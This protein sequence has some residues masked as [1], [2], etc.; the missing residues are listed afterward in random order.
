MDDD[1]NQLAQAAH[2]AT[3]RV[4]AS[5]VR[6]NQLVIQAP[7]RPPRR[8]SAF[9][10]AFF[11]TFGVIAALVC[12]VLL[13][14]LADK[15]LERRP[16]STPKSESRAYELLREAKVLRQTVADTDQKLARLREQMKELESQ[17]L[18]VKSHLEPVIASEAAAAKAQFEAT[19]TY[20]RAESD[21]A[22]L[23]AARQ[24]DTPLERVEAA[25]AWNR[26]RMELQ[27]LRANAIL[28]APKRK[29][30]LDLEAKLTDLG[31]K[32]R[33]LQAQIAEIEKD[34][35][36]QKELLTAAENELIRPLESLSVGAWGIL[37]R[38]LTVVQVVDGENFIARDEEETL[39]CT[40]ISTNGM[41]DGSSWYLKKPLL[42]AGTTSYSDIRGAKR[43][44]YQIEPLGDLPDAPTTQPLQ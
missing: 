3:Q 33:S 26:A 14:G 18:D 40:G 19:D 16:A 9:F 8:R 24:K 42:V 2:S 28:A 7:G 13:I 36:H 25:G 34:S 15:V 22:A 35:I 20:R 29:V 5:R 6:P 17:G 37:K 31:V 21:L 38:P 41:V 39:W 32:A 30:H 23:D 27:K 43:T 44:V 4:A 12:C 10:A 11:A 1:L